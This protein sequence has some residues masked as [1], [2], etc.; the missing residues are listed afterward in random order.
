MIIFKAS[1]LPITIPYSPPPII[2]HNSKILVLH[3]EF[4][5]A[6]DLN[7]IAFLMGSTDIHE[8]GRS[9]FTINYSLP[10]KG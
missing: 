10:Q 1:L 6:T 4:D 8:I 7:E 3:C 5:S 2:L 9:Q